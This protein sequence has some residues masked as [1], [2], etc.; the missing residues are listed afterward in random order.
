LWLI[1]ESLYCPLLYGDLIVETKLHLSDRSEWIRVETDPA[2]CKL[3]NR[4]VGI[5]LKFDFFNKYNYNNQ[6]DSSDKCEGK[7]KYRFGDKKKKF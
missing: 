5:F 2:L 4:D 1:P 6:N 3:H 7:K